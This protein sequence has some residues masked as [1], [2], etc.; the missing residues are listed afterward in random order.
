MD[1]KVALGLLGMTAE[2]FWCTTPC[3]LRWM[4]EG[5]QERRTQLYEDM[6]VH[7]AWIVSHLV[8]KPVHPDKL[9]GRKKTR[10]SDLHP[11]MQDYL[12]TK[13]WAEVKH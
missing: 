10:T 3:E 6:A 7:A 9:L 4:I 8:G 2:Q 11:D 1:R 13:R 12:L 5:W